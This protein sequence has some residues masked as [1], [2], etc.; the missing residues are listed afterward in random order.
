MLALVTVTHVVVTVGVPA[1]AEVEDPSLICLS[2]KLSAPRL[3]AK[4]SNAE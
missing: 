4:L 1:E 2:G 3:I